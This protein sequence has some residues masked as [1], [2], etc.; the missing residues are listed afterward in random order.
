MRPLFCV[1][2]YN[3]NLVWTNA[4]NKHTG[5]ISIRQHVS[6]NAG[7][8][9]NCSPISKQYMH[10]K[11]TSKSTTCTVNPIKRDAPEIKENQMMCRQISQ[12]YRGLQGLEFEHVYIIDHKSTSYGYQSNFQLCFSPSTYLQISVHNYGQIQREFK[13]S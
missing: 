6:M 2:M 13:C 1:Y 9:S 3:V 7:V 10:C 5:K 12:I 4:C 8:Q 11:H